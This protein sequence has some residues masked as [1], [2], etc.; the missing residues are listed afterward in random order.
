MA[1]AR[2][3][4][5]I[6]VGGCLNAAHDYFE[7]VP[8]W[9]LKKLKIY[10][11][12]SKTKIGSRFTSIRTPQILSLGPRLTSIRTPRPREH[13][14]EQPRHLVQVAF[15]VLLRTPVSRDCCNGFLRIYTPGPG[16]LYIVMS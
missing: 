7:N 16:M 15:T 14:R 10:A 4:F 11:P 5:L 3:N 9:M 8:V 6:S 2:D 1:A 13:A 12:L